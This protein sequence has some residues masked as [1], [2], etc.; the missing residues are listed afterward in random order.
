MKNKITVL[1]I[2]LTFTISIYAQL[3]WQEGG[4]PVNHDYPLYWYENSGAVINDISYFVW[5][6]TQSGDPDLLMQGYDIDGEP[7]WQSDLI[8]C[9]APKYQ[10]R[11]QII[12]AS[13]GNIIIAWHDTRD[14]PG[15][16]FGEDY[17]IYLQK[18]T[19]A[20]EMLWENNGVFVGLCYPYDYQI[21]SDDQ[22][23][24][25]LG[26]RTDTGHE[27]PVAFWHIISDG[28]C[29]PN[30]E[31]GI[32]IEGIRYNYIT[33]S[34]GDGN[35]IIYS[36]Q[37]SI[38][39]VNKLSPL[40]DLIWDDISIIDDNAFNA[41]IFKRENSLDILIDVSNEI[42]MQQINDNGELMWEEPVLIYSSPSYMSTFY[43]T[44][45]LDGY[46]LNF[47]QYQVSNILL[48]INYQGE[49]VWT[50]ELEA[51]YGF[52][53]IKGMSN[54][55][56]RLWDYSYAEF[57]IWEYDSDGNITGPEEGLW[58]ITFPASIW[59]LTFGVFGEGNISAMCW[60][61]MNSEQ[62]NEV[63]RYQLINE[64]SEII[65]GEDGEE[66]SRG[67]NSGLTC[68]GIYKIDDMEIVLMNSYYMGERQ[69]IMKLFDEDGN[70]A[71][72]PEGLPISD[73]DANYT[74]PLGI[75]N[76]RFYFIMELDDDGN[77]DSEVLY[78]NAV[79]F[80]GEPELVWGEVGRYLGEGEF[81][82]TTINLTT[83]PGE[84]NTLLFIW[85]VQSPYGYGRVQK[86]VDDEFVWQNGG[87]IYPWLT[88]DTHRINAYNDYILRMISW[89]N[90]YY[91]NRVDENGEMM[92]DDEL[93]LNLTALYELPIAIPQEN[94]NMLF[95][96]GEY[97]A[98]GL[99]LVEFRI[100]PEGENL[101]SNQGTV[102]NFLNGA[103]YL[104][105]FDCGDSYAVVTRQ[106]DNS[107]TLRRYHY[108][109]TEIAEPV[110]IPDFDYYEILNVE[111]LSEHLLIYTQ[112]MF[113]GE[114]LS[115][116][117]FNGQPSELLPENPY[118][119]LEMSNYYSGAINCKDGDDIYFCWLEGGTSE[120]PDEGEY[121]FNWYM[122]KFRIPSTENTGDDII[123]STQL[124]LYPNPFNPE[125]NIS[126]EA[127]NMEN[128]NTEIA[129][130][131]IKGQQIRSWQTESCR[132]CLTW[133]GKN[134]K[135]LS[136]S[137]GIYFV[138]ITTGGK[139][140]SHKAVL[141]K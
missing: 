19:P 119:Y 95:L 53:G 125:L 82:N 39:T 132:G 45:A 112:T 50:S 65:C 34:D 24:C 33:L 74:E 117:D 13:D 79:D 87:L 101:S 46:Y 10:G 25:Y 58:N 17:D 135:G 27:N 40:G 16:Y 94:G 113:G 69:M 5:S 9:D 85:N 1:L 18:I 57:T 61:E 8:I 72:D 3:Q 130:Y 83:I 60:R 120:R 44:P 31:T 35:L 116:Y 115:V 124:Q 103:E 12:A 62:E 20:G 15:L 41:H 14:R 80:S 90:G 141:L 81:I 131:N 67:R 21:I 96:L 71:G 136:C 36:A 63:L 110:S 104:E 138:R 97:N 76:D 29:C 54:G 68:K 91:L 140:I 73:A 37:D 47:Y 86:I 70:I 51:N 55:N 134:D 111:I 114:K 6:D 38:S 23:G 7:V 64:E 129:V 106:D 59:N 99:Q 107:L 105:I 49:L 88:F 93:P 52:D 4:I 133:D 56:V 126:W 32:I 48:R 22:G 11:G 137:T 77:P 109:S 108:D 28:T 30:W 118:Q 26:F 66:I 121:G 139:S 89:G 2:F 122:Q 127:E 43:C 84:D 92:W 78:I 123:N 98:A 102:V 42:Y 100:T 75:Y 128:S